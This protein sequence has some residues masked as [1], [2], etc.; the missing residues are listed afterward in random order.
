M[1]DNRLPKKAWAAN[2]FLQKPRKSKV[3]LMGWMLDMQRWFKRWGVDRYLTM[4]LE[5]IC[6][7][8]FQKSLLYTYQATQKCQGADGKLAYY[9]MHIHPSCWESYM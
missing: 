9:S 5:D 6:M 1:D 2:T 3:L 8:A 4:M 7:D